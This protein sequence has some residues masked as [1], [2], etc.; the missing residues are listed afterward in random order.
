MRNVL[1]SMDKRTAVCVFDFAENHLCRHQDEVASAHWGYSQV[2]VHPVVCHYRPDGGEAVTDYQVFLSDDL[3]HDSAMVQAILDK[4]VLHLKTRLPNLEKIVV[5]S[6]GCAAQYKSRLPFFHLANRTGIP[7]QWN[8][9]GSRHGK[10]LCD[11]CGGVVKR[12]VD[13]DVLASDV[14][15]QNAAQMYEHCNQN[16]QLPEDDSPSSS[17]TSI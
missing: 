11:A 2:T 6:D 5:F 16:Y 14:V 12:L 9:F 17:T 3:N 15:V 1:S 7:I 10:S 8:F 4:V 13:E